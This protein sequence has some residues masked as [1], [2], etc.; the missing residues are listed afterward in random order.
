MICA[1]TE[2]T[3]RHLTKGYNN[4]YIET[5]KR[6]Q[7]IIYLRLPTRTKHK[8]PSQASPPHTTQKPPQCKTQMLKT[9][10]VRNPA[11]CT[12][13]AKHHNPN[14]HSSSLFL[15]E[16]FI[17]ACL[18]LNASANPPATLDPLSLAPAS[19]FEYPLSR[20]IGVAAAA[21][22]P[23]GRF[24]GGA[25]GVGFPL[26]PFAGLTGGGGGGGGTTAL[27]SSI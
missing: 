20:A 7:C 15:F 6:H 21:L 26:V 25:G 22:L 11:S 13:D 2:P 24:E 9:R 19:W 16:L 12:D 5:T 17:A 1:L 8:S 18:A 3:N 27:I 23:T 10:K 4:F 14:H